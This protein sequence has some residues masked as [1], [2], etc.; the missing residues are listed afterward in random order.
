MKS[1]QEAFFDIN[2]PIHVSK[3]FSL[4]QKDIKSVEDIIKWMERYDLDEM[5]QEIE[6]KID[7]AL[8]GA[9]DN[10]YFNLNLLVSILR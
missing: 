2:K 4:N 10:E 1:Q 7:A 6:S 9:T 8:S 3:N 5:S